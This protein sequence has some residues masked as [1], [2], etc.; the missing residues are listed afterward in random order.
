ME[1]RISCIFLKVAVCLLL[2]TSNGYG[3]DES[4][5][6]S[7]SPIIETRILRTDLSE[8]TIDSQDF[9][10]GLYLGQI[11]IE[12]LTTVPLLGI[13]GTYHATEDLFLEAN[14]AVATLEEPNTS[15]LNQSQA[16]TDDQLVMFNFSLGFNLLP[17]EAFLGSEKV[18]NSAFYI[19]GGVGVTQFDGNE[20]FTINLGFGYR[21]I[22]MEGFAFHLDAREH[23]FNRS[24]AGSE[25]NSK[26]LDFHGGVTY[27]F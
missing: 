9:E 18:F 15:K 6:S 8:S 5:Q 24:V 13:S 17:G 22:M 26:N 21:I 10:V 23:V 1:S 11:S 4:E 20:E 19:V 12:E 7:L 3:S 14:Y 27:F 16:F 2:T 25:R